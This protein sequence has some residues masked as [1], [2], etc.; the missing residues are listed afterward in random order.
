MTERTKGKECLDVRAVHSCT[1]AYYLYIGRLEAFMS[2]TSAILDAKEAGLS[3][4]DEGSA[5]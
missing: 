2:C 4:V 5:Q 3:E 1:R